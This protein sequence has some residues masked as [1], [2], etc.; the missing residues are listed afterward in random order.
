[1]AQTI[2]S[3]EIF[4]SGG[5]N[6]YC[7]KVHIPGEDPRTIDLDVQDNSF[8]LYTHQYKLRAYFGKPVQPKSTKATFIHEKSVL[9]IR[10]AQLK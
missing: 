5:K 2:S 10:V 3:L 7:C 1:M 6:Y 4:N 8:Y 9:E